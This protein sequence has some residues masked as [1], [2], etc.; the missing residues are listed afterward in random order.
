MNTVIKEFINKMVLAII[1]T[2]LCIGVYIFADYLQ[3]TE[4]YLQLPQQIKMT[5]NFLDVVT[6][7]ACA[8]TALSQVY[9]G[10]KVLITERHDLPWQLRTMPSQNNTPSWNKEY[11]QQK[12]AIRRRLENSEEFNSL[13]AN[14]EWFSAPL[15]PFLITFEGLKKFVDTS[16]S[17]LQS[18]PDEVTEKYAWELFKQYQRLDNIAKIFPRLEAEQLEYRKRLAVHAKASG[19]IQPPW[20]ERLQRRTLGYAE[21][22]LRIIEPRLEDYPAYSAEWENYKEEDRRNFSY[23][24][25][26]LDWIADSSYGGARSWFDQKAKTEKLLADFSGWPTYKFTLQ[27]QRDKL[28]NETEAFGL[29]DS[30]EEPDYWHKA[31][32]LLNDQDDAF[33]DI[34]QIIEKCQEQEKDLLNSWFELKSMLKKLGIPADNDWEKTARESASDKNELQILAIMKLLFQTND[35][36]G[37]DILSATPNWQLIK[38]QLEGSKKLIPD[39]DIEDIEL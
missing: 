2:G 27:G 34:E 10:A 29:L 30:T 3:Q 1:A 32:Q 36:I 26:Q 25:E 13:T 22:L 39:D 7:L 24:L 12:S 35:S 38:Y 28:Q 19:L 33:C 15:K 37:Q 17:E 14:V 11:M 23:L 8:I 6:L 20:L 9:L 4:S 5:I 16:D 31:K 21:N 18:H